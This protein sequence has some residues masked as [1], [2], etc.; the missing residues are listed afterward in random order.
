MGHHK[1]NKK[2]EG[3]PRTDHGSGLPLRPDDEQL[4]ERTELDRIAMGLPP[5]PDATPADTD[6]QAAYTEATDEID[7]QVREGE[8]RTDED[9]GRAAGDAFPPT[10]YTSGD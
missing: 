9:S 6:P 3:G 2:V 1:S 10:R 4:E 8:L 7:D 5:D